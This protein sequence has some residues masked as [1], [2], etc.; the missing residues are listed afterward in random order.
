[1][2]PDFIE[3]V[4]RILIAIGV[5]AVIGA[6]REYGDKSAGFRTMIMISTGACL[7]T[8]LSI[9][10]GG[11]D[12]ST[13]IAA[14]IVTGVGFLGAGAILRDGGRLM[15]LTTASAIWLTAALGMGVGGGHVE[16]ILFATATILIVLVIFPYIERIIDS[17]RDRRTY[18]VTC[19][20]T[21]IAMDEADA[22][23]R[24]AGLRV[25]HV[26]R[27]KKGGTLIGSWVTVGSPRQHV[28]AAQKLLAHPDIQEFHA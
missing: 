4:V 18:H 28:A 20:T 5:G 19:A 7:F 11:P 25:L 24:E 2:A 6:E 26:N 22:I 9:R 10:I 16:L 8:L 21:S 1:M 15:G 14:N 3:A 17:M 12:D 23:L 27:N 13:R